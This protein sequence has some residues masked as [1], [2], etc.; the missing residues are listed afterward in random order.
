MG[1]SS[2]LLNESPK[3]STTGSDGHQL[4]LRCIVAFR[5]VAPLTLVASVDASSR[6]RNGGADARAVCGGVDRFG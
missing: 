3:P 4:A 1:S 2:E 6:R 5:D